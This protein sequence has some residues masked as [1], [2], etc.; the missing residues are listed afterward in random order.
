MRWHALSS[1]GGGESALDRYAEVA[2]RSQLGREAPLHIASDATGIAVI[3]TDSDLAHTALQLMETDRRL[4]I[5]LIPTGESDLLRMFGLNRDRMLARLETGAPYATDLGMCHISASHHPFVGSVCARPTRWRRLVSTAAVSVDL[6]GRTHDLDAWEVVV[7]NA[8]HVDGQT[9]APRAAV[10]DGTL[11]VQV[12]GGPPTRRPAVRRFRRTGLHLRS[13]HVWRRSAP[14]FAISVPA[15]WRIAA[16]LV[17]VGTGSFSVEI[18]PGAFDL[19][20]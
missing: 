7:A 15:S 17:A 10:M 3:G 6:R 8:Q 14:T 12:F 16:D 9:I 18:A 4:P 13:G 5:A 19:W 20:I 1:S 11:D 2:Q